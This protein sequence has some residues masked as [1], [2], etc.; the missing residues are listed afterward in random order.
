MNKRGAKALSKQEGPNI[1]W[2]A[3]FFNPFFESE[4]VPSEKKDKKRASQQRVG[5]SYFVR[6]LVEMCVE[7]EKN[8][9]Q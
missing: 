7:G 2:D 8:Q 6:A 5:P 1:R 3:R 9:N 4:S